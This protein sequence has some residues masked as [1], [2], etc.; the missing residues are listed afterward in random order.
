MGHSVGAIIGFILVMRLA[1]KETRERTKP[2]EPPQP[3]ATQNGHL[4]PPRGQGD[5]SHQGMKRRSPRFREDGDVTAT[6]RT[7]SER[8]L[9]ATKATD[10]KDT[11][12]SLTS[13]V[14]A[15][16]A[17]TNDNGSLSRTQHHQYTGKPNTQQVNEWT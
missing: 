12:K 3:P 17:I 15:E 11:L 10:S 13:T 4:S 2:N 16:Q 6:N 14:E 9:G 8:V 5:E 1:I 7:H